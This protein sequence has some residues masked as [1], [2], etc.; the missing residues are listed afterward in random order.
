MY[1]Y[2]DNFTEVLKAQAYDEPVTLEPTAA[3]VKK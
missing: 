2:D 3:V 1:N